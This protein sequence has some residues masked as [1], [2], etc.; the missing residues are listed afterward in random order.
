M[1][2]AL[3][4]A[5]MLGISGCGAINDDLPPC[6]EGVNL[7][8]VFDYNME[9]ANAFPSQ[10]DCLTLLVYDQNG[11]YITTRTETSSVLADE[12]W[13][14]TLDL[15]AGQTYHFVAY[16]GM[17][18]EK[19]TFHFVNTPAAGTTLSQLAVSM[20]DN[21]IDADPGVNLHPLF[22]GDLDLTVPEG[23]LDYTAGTVYMMRD[24][25]TIRILLQNT[26]LTPVD[27]ADFRFEITDNN[28]LLSFDNSVVPTASGITY[29]PWATGQVASGTDS[30][31][32]EAILAYAEFAT[33]RLINR[34]GAR[35]TVT[36]V[37]NGQP[38]LSIPLVNYLLLYK[39]LRY[40]SMPSQEYL[41]REHH[42]DMILFLNDNVWVSAYIVVNDWMVRLNSAD[43]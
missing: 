28:T 22:Y 11:N 30:D 25:N 41:D 37:S 16:G 32:Q 35:L 14:M 2:A 36:R 19:S 15:P 29:S 12:N 13:R 21:C 8:F 27:P 3:A 26:N 20:N 24:T 18:C 23:A 6:P 4:V 1:G 10:V 34:S 33:S 38:V 39:S 5:S 9:F 40:E 31:S 7:R 42:W 43:L 17:E